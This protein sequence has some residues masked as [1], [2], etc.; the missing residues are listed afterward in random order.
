MICKLLFTARNAKKLQQFITALSIANCWQFRK[1]EKL[2]TWRMT[3]KIYAK[4]I[5]NFYPIICSSVNLF[6]F[7][8]VILHG[9]G[10]HKLQACMASGKHFTMPSSKSMLFYYKLLV[11]NFLIE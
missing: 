9:D 4:N 7:T 5:S 10:L 6:F 3:W 8:P 1:G 11:V 2:L